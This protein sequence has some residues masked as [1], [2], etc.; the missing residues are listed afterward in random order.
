MKYFEGKTVLLTGA[1]SG[2]GC[3]FLR[4]LS[5]ISD[6]KIVIA[7]RT[8]DKLASLVSK[9]EGVRAYV[10]TAK[11]DL[12]STDK[13]IDEAISIIFKIYGRIDVLLNCAGM[14]FR[15][16]IVDTIPDVDRRILQVDYFGQI[17]VIKSLCRKWEQ[18]AIS[19][20]DVVQISSVQGFI[21]IGDRAPYAAAKHALVGF[22]DCLRTEF[23]EYPKTSK[24]RVMLACPGYIATNHSVNSITGE[25]KVYSMQDPAT[26]QGASPDEVANRIL[27]GCARG[28]REMIIA[29][30]KTRLLILFRMLFPS[31]CFRLLRNR[32]A[33][34]K[35]SLVCSVFKWILSI[36][37]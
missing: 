30:W 33:G 29:D 27:E 36:T 8:P 20:W 37:S 35:E 24:R 19:T 6:C 9:L 32:Y 23:D 15:G 16:K 14:G 10:R 3:S 25:G 18:E 31:L 7:G 28:E 17:A 21:G 5:R 1:S 13:D 26:L 4:S 22:I 12:D 11:L 2:L 34:I